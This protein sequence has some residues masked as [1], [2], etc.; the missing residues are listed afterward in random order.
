MIIEEEKAKL[1]VCPT[2][3]ARD[4]SSDGKCLGAGCMAW[5]PVENQ[6][7]YC[8]MAGAPLPIVVSGM[9]QA[10]LASM[11]ISATV[12]AEYKGDRGPGS[13]N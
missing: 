6:S 12:S 11:G 5:R 4:T 7:G 13:V 3:R 2:S 1:F 9:T 8:G 10:A